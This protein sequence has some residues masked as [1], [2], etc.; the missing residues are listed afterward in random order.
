MSASL[1]SFTTPSPS[2][3]HLTGLDC[4]LI[5]LDRRHAPWRPERPGRRPDP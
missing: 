2:F 3:N 5:C 1:P 4:N